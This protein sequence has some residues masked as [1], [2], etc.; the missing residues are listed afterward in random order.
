MVRTGAIYLFISDGVNEFISLFEVW[1]RGS[2]PVPGFFLGGEYA[3]APRG[4]KKINKS[5]SW[6]WRPAFNVA[7]TQ[8]IQPVR[9]PLIILVFVFLVPLP[10]RARYV[11]PFH[12]RMMHG[13]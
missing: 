12:S 13:R 3:G 8:P 7:A 10:R 2:T 4:A 1:G 5:G 11:P 9:A 6:V